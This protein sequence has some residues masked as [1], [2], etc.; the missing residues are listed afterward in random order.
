MRGIDVRG[1]PGL[2]LAGEDVPELGEGV[3]QRRVVDR[4]VEVLDDDV[5]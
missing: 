2:D 4:L 1:A 5:A 3:V